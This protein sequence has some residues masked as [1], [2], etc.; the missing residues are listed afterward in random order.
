MISNSVLPSASYPLSGD[1]DLAVAAD[2]G[3]DLTAAAVVA[4]EPTVDV[5]CAGLTFI[6][7]SGITMLIDVET[8]SGKQVRLLN[9]AAPCRRVF[10]ALDLCERF[11]VEGSSPP[12][13]L[14]PSPLPT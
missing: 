7:A 8:R 10:E 11:S 14:V 12:L 4:S 5:D 3:R 6:D 13:R 9:V 1:V 2:I